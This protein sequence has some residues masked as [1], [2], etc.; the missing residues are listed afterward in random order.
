M[1]EFMQAAFEQAQIGT[2][3]GGFPVGSVIVKADRIVG[4]GHNRFTQSGDPTSHAELEAIRDTA[5]RHGPEEG[6]ALLGGATCYTTMM[7]CEMCS[8]AI[9]RFGLAR[10]VVGE[11]T[12]YTPAATRTL[13]ERQGIEV[14]VHQ[15]SECI[16]LAESYLAI[17][18]DEAELA[19]PVRPPLKL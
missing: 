6:S 10:V 7:P 16:A 4:A 17:H 9:I 13:L 19:V 18:A 14:E 5:R 8:G 3:D 15:E 12:S 1:D 11:T 2:Q